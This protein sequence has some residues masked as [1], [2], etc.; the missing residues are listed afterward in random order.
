[1]ERQGS[2]R[3]TSV[4]EIE[5]LVT[6]EALQAVAET[7]YFLYNARVQMISQRDSRTL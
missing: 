1:M 5:I 7:A 4:I 2:N 3:G 6:K